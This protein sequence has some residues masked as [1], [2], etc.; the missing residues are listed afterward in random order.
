MGGAALGGE[1]AGQ[2]SK[3]KGW[4]R[5]TLFNHHGKHRNNQ[6]TLLMQ[7]F[8]QASDD[9]PVYPCDMLSSVA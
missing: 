4:S 9:S 7:I 6:D 5:I 1:R 8:I 3:T 2:A